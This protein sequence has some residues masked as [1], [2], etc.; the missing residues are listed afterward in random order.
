MLEELAV[1]LRVN[2]VLTVAPDEGEET[3][4]VTAEAD[5]IKEK[6]N[7]A[8]SNVRILVSAIFFSFLRP[9]VASR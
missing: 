4:T 7:R 5:V 6:S 2:E 8:E 3:V 9:R 1:H